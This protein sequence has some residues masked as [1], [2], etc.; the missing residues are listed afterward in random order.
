MGCT[1]SSWL[2]PVAEGGGYSPAAARG[3]Y[4][5]AAVRGGYSPAAASGGY[6]PVATGGGYC[7]AAARGGYSPA[8]ARVLL[9]VVASL[10]VSMASRCAGSVAAANALGCSAACGSNPCPLHWQA[11]SQ[12]LKSGREFLMLNRVSDSHGFIVLLPSILPVT[13]QFIP[14]TVL[15]FK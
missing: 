9:T 5:P 2:S 14:K 12:P 10:A 15:Q 11:D 13:H 1:S 8:A 4:S 7:P 6:S 3:G